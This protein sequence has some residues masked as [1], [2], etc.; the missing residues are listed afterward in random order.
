MNLAGKS[1]APA[2]CLCAFVAAVHTPARAANLL[3]AGLQSLAASPT[4][5]ES[6][7]RLHS[8]AQSQTDPQWSGWAYFLAGYREYQTQLFA[9]AAHDLAQAAQSGFALADFAVYYQATALHQAN[10]SQEAAAALQDFPTRFPTSHIQERALSLGVNCLLNA[11]QPQQAADALAGQPVVSRQASFALLYAQSCLQAHRL[12]EAARAFQNVCYHFPAAPEAKPASSGLHTLLAELGGAYPIPDDGLRLARAAALFDAERYADA[13]K[14][15]NDLLRDKPNSPDVTRWELGRSRC[16]V[17]LHRTPDAL[18]ALSVHY[19]APEQEAERMQLLVQVHAQQ[20][21]TAAMADD[22]AQFDTT[23]P[24]SPFYADALSTVGAYYYRQ[25]NWP[26]AAR[27]YRRLYVLF[28]QNDHWRDD[29]WRLAWCDYLVHDSQTAEVMSSYLR[30]FPDSPR[31]PSALYW[32]ARVE[33]ERG[34]AADAR[35]LYALLIRRFVHSYYAPRAAVR[36]ATLRS[37]Q[38]ATAASNDAAPMAA[39]LIPVLAAPVAPP[40]L[41]CLATSPG[42]LAR[43]AVILAELNLPD[44]EQEYL[45]AALAVDNPPAELRLLLAEVDAAQKNTIGAFFAAMRTVPDYPRMEFSD[46]PKEVWDYLYP[47]N[48]REIIDA[49][50][51]RYNLDPYLVMG[52]V[53]QESGFYPRALSTAN[54]RGLM[55]LLPQTAARSNR[56]ARVLAAER[57][58]YDPTYNVQAGCTFLAELLREFDNKPALAVAAYNAGDFRVRDWV[59]KFSITDPELF[60]ESIPFSATR[61]YTEA[62]LR[63]A[64]IYRQLMSGSPRFAQCSRA[65]GVAATAREKDA[66]AASRQQASL[67]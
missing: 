18:Q 65:P 62:V 63:D 33:E 50:A 5:S 60:L 11:H 10:R 1:V 26:E 52:L 32:L 20:S 67:N 45:R 25:F 53:R 43:P 48:Y 16:L 3:P 39:A 6:L 42:A 27:V 31:A 35:A 8:Y 41:A 28:P 66:S 46:L 36:M 13:L 54:A 29:G 37:S 30:S 15:Y 12:Q 19:A 9:D 23:Y 57:R 49:Q 22:L 55:Q 14:D 7:P 59:S 2:L 38:R 44:V 21:D 4:H 40:G 64:E 51:R 24:S 61:I 56:R 58:L 34:A 17:R 47:Q